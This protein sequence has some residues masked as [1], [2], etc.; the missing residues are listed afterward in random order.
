MPDF[1]IKKGGIAIIAKGLNVIKA[2]A[3]YNCTS[4]ESIAIPIG[5][6]EIGDSAFK[7]CTK[8]TTVILP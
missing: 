2:N 6:S 1:E 4:L 5:I 7:G 8:L 3:F